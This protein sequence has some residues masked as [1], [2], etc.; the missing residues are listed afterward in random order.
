VS[1]NPIKV[2]EKQSGLIRLLIYLSEKSPINVQ[3]IIDDS[4]IYPNIMYASI[5]K[6]KEIALIEDK[7]DNSKY[8][9]RTMLSL[10][11]KGR[12]VAQKLKEIEEILKG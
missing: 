4:D 11:E 8:P 9:P 10:T 2:L 3:S 1:E 12:R 5:R 6:A 7:V